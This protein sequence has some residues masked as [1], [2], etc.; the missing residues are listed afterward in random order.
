MIDGNIPENTAKYINHARKPNCEAV[1]PSGHIY[2]FS[3]RN[4]K[5]GEELTYD[6]G[7]D[8]VEKYITPTGCKCTTCMK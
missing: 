6:Y 5:A 3:I 1:G 7:D 2:I 8:Y 4:I